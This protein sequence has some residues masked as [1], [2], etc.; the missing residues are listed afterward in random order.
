MLTLRTIFNGLNNMAIDND[1]ITIKIKV[2]Y[3][4]VDGD[5]INTRWEISN[6]EYI[7]VPEYISGVLRDNDTLPSKFFDASGRF[8]RFIMERKPKVYEPKTIR[9]RKY[10]K[11]AFYRMMDALELAIPLLKEEHIKVLT[12]VNQT[13]V[14]LGVSIPFLIEV[15]TSVSL[16]EAFR[17][18]TWFSNKNRYLNVPIEINNK[19]YWITNHI[20]DRNIPKVKELLSKMVGI[21]YL[22][23]ECEQDEMSEQAMSLIMNMITEGTL[24]KNALGD[25]VAQANEDEDDSII[26]THE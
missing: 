20:F 15:D 10:A 24:P 3:D 7:N 9:E 12:D 11:S 8:P 17:K 25:I 1:G 5:P 4:P 23:D 2:E 18:Q 19:K 6:A 26:V 21:N 14:L 16:E 22:P 13:K